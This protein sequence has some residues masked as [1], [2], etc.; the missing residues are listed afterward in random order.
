M[1]RFLKYA[2]DITV[3][4]FAVLTVLLIV[5]SVIGV[6]PYITISGSMEP[7]IL[8]GSV[9]FVNTKTH[10]DDIQINDII[11]FRAGGNTLVTHRVIGI[12]EDGVTTKGD[13]NE[14]ADSLN[15][16][17][18]NY[19]GETLF[20]IPYIGYAVMLLK[21]PVGLVLIIAI[22]SLLVLW[23]V[24]DSWKPKEKTTQN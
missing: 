2:S 14:D 24:K 9:C 7:T 22:L 23:N 15:T 3:Y 16:T 4:G 17:K 10:Y 6:K 11:A 8:T 21:K 18:D 13:N 1:K 12:D 19:V 5:L 20:S